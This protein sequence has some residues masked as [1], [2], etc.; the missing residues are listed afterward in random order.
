MEQFYQ[1]NRTYDNGGA[2][3]APAPTYKNFA[4]A[5]RVNNGGQGYV[6]TA[7]GSSGR[8]TGFTFS[9]D[10]LNARQTTSGPTGWLSATQPCFIVRKNSCT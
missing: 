9:I 4:H 10:N 5:C 7:T 2:C 6:A 1:D 8:T 3:G